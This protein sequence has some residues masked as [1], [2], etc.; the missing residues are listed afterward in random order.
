MTA[1]PVTGPNG[2]RLVQV[3]VT[4]EPDPAWVGHDW[5]QTEIE[6]RVKSAIT[7]APGLELADDDEQTDA[8]RWPTP[9]PIEQIPHTGLCL[10]CKERLA[11]R[12]KVLADLRRLETTIRECG[13]WSEEVRRG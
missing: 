3:T 13:M 11:K 5:H 7:R 4:V 8:T 2:E 1:H 9:D 12:D 6:D 10:A